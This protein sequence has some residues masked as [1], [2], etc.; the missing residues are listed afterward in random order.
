MTMNLRRIFSPEHATKM[1]NEHL[2]A[3]NARFLDFR[4]M[5]KNTITRLEEEVFRLR[6]QIAALERDR[7][8]KGRFRC[9]P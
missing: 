3:E 9:A 2:R 7:D 6:R 4:L 5:D 1:E 8:N